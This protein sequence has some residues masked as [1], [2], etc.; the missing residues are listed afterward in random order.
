MD[1]SRGEGQ[2]ALSGLF[3]LAAE[4]LDD[5][6]WATHLR[7]RRHHSPGEIV[8]TIK[9]G[10]LSP[11]PESA[12]P[13]AMTLKERTAVASAISTSEIDSPRV[14]SML[15]ALVT[16][17][18]D[19]T[20]A[21]AVIETLAP[22]QLT[23]ALVTNITLRW[24][25]SLPV[26]EAYTRT[27][28]RNVRAL[29][30][31]WSRPLS[32]HL[33][34]L[35]LSVWRAHLEQLTQQVESGDRAAEWALL[36]AMPIPQTDGPQ[37]LRRATNPARLLT[38]A[39]LLR[40]T[41]R[42]PA[43]VWLQAAVRVSATMI[44][45]AARAQGIE[46]RTG[47]TIRE[48]IA[49]AAAELR[50]GARALERAADEAAAEKA[51]SM[52]GKE[53][54]ALAGRGDITNLTTM[55]ATHPLQVLGMKLD[56]LCGKAPETQ[57]EGLLGVLRDWSSRAREVAAGEE[58]AT[59]LGARATQ[60][61]VTGQADMRQTLEAA[62]L[63]MSACG[64]VAACPVGL[65]DEESRATLWSLADAAS[66]DATFDRTC[67]PTPEDVAVLNVRHLK[68]IVSPGRDAAETLLELIC[69]HASS[70][71][72]AAE[73]YRIAL[74]LLEGFDGTAGDLAALCVAALQ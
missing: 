57:A 32:R 38:Q 67:A 29:D 23:E 59:A 8:A 68:G 24:R 6:V 1:R 64:T 18:P 69:R 9:S 43:R 21:A 72:Q 5:A 51:V 60:L 17:A 41:A 45:E 62:E 58:W 7:L 34:N 27:A 44:D 35:S 48:E 49:D 25:D 65:L 31:L 52:W 20:D 46:R 12:A 11:E 63:L 53:I 28:S 47:L 10:L 40:S 26:W 70:D 54:T 14:R 50:L 36:E 37:D 42:L 61:L 39:H 16:T 19:E 33:Q 13:H 15:A 71:Q 55:M 56:A 74:S 66:A 30:V 73:A 4:S 2:A 22:E 3:N